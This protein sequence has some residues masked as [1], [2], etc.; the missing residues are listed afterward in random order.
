MDELNVFIGGRTTLK[1]IGYNM[2]NVNKGNLL[3]HK[4]QCVQQ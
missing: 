3:I 1:T 2:D 4:I